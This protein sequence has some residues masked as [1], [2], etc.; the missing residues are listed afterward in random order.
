MG[1]H[2]TAYRANKSVVDNAVPH[3]NNKFLLKMDFKNFFHQLLR[4]IS[5]NTWSQTGLLIQ[6]IRMNSNYS[7]IY[8][9]CP[10]GATLS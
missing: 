9:S 3:L 7:Q 2:A 4:M 10:R 5:A 8:Y 1:L 6:I